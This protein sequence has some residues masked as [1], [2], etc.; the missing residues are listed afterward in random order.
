M[1]NFEVII[2]YIIISCRLRGSHID[3]D[4]SAENSRSPSLSGYRRLDF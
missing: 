2:I 4:F 1:N 3:S